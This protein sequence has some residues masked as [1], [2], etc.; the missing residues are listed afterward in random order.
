MMFEGAHLIFEIFGD[1]VCLF[2]V[3]GAVPKGDMEEVF[4]Y[5]FHE[6]AAWNVLEGVERLKELEPA[7]RK[8]VIFRM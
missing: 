2:S 5:D 1:E 6:D 4:L 3:K 7:L 8:K